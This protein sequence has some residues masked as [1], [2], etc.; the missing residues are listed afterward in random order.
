MRG[1]RQPERDEIVVPDVVAMAQEEASGLRFVPGEFQWVDLDSIEPHPRNANEGDV[2]AIAEA[3]DEVGFF[4]LM[5]V[6][7][8]APGRF[9][10][11]DGEHRWLALRQ[12]HGVRGPCWV[13]DVPDDE[14]AL[15]ILTVQNRSVRLGRD[16]LDVQIENLT[17]LAGSPSG[18]A[19][20][21]FDGDDLDAL[22]AELGPAPVLAPDPPP[23]TG[24][25][26]RA[27][28]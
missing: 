9:Q 8:I 11:L 2:G 3:V 16:R 23:A 24:V 1:K 13:M 10:L 26:R 27:D 21:G 19:G 7:E 25:R 17:T 15:R 22:I 5:Y 6:R 28:P 14:A 18:L 4:G 20:T 12:K